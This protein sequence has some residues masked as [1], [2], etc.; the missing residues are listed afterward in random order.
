MWVITEL[1]KADVA[2]LTEK[3]TVQ[4]SGVVMVEGEALVGLRWVAADSA[5]LRCVR[6]APPPLF[7]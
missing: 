5:P 3:P 2:W 7:S 6:R 4:S 1:A